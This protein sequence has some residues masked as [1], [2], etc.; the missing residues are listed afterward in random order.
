M[1]RTPQSLVPIDGEPEWLAAL[2][3][4]ARE[5]SIAAAGAKIN[6]SRTAVSLLLAGKYPAKSLQQI[7]RACETAFQ[8][9]VNCPGLGEEIPADVC[10]EW[11]EKPFAATS[12][13][14]VTMYRACQ[15]CPNRPT[16]KGGSHVE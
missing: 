6:R 3:A 15:S 16:P 4:Y 14:R 10:R 7:R 8:G 2:R 12:S 5:T 9:R 11:A 1:S 13:Q